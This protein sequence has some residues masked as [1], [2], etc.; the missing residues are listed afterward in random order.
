MGFRYDMR[1]KDSQI[2][3]I[4]RKKDEEERRREEE[5]RKK[6]NKVRCNVVPNNGAYH[7]VQ[8]TR[9]N[10]RILELRISIAA[11]FNEPCGL[12]DQDV[13]VWLCQTGKSF[14]DEVKSFETLVITSLD[15]INK[16]LITNWKNLKREEQASE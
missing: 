3:A 4:V 15:V 10:K 1:G 7:A 16:E 11:I 2:Q 8:F 9:D 12:K 6:K 13:A 14:I 5:Y